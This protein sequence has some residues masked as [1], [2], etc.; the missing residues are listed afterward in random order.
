MTD[1]LHAS[2]RPTRPIDEAIR[3]TDAIGE[4]LRGLT[5]DRREMTQ[6]A[7]AVETSSRDTAK[8][9]D[10]I[11]EVAK[12][13]KILSINAAIKAA[14]AGD[15]GRGFAVVA[16]EV[17]KLSLRTE[18]AVTETHRLLTDSRSQID[19]LLKLFAR[20]DERVTGLSEQQQSLE[21][22]LERLQYQASHGGAEAGAE[23]GPVAGAAGTPVPQ[24]LTFDATTMATGEET[25]DCQHR[26]LI[27]MINDLDRACAEGHGRAEVDKALDFLASYVIDHF[28][29]EEKQFDARRCPRA[30]ENRQAHRQLVEQYTKWREQY[31]ASGA[32]LAMVGEL[33]QFLRDWL[34]SHICGTDTSLRG[35]GDTGGGC[36]A[37]EALAPRPAA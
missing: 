20:L 11:A 35:T 9:T 1:S 27:D 21:S 15:T 12:T 31:D 7:E 24:A 4:L 16:D 10:A 13:T 29:Y 8:V 37:A 5:D 14:R 3:Q 18:Q 25:V 2:A 30:E 6:A 32:S 19:A 17:N 26:K 33:V 34:V 23:P 28:A 22:E 36:G